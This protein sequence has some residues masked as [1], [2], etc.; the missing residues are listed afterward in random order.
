LEDRLLNAN[1]G[2]SLKRV[3]VKEINKTG[4]SLTYQRKILGT[5]GTFK[6]DCALINH[7]CRIFFDKKALQIIFKE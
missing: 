1:F 5:N 7:T 2:Y 3:G 6:N 4:W